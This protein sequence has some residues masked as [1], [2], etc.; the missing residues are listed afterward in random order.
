MKSRHRA[1]PALLVLTTLSVLTA[2]V[3]AQT[4]DEAPT[5]CCIEVYWVGSEVGQLRFIAAYTTPV[6]RQ[7][8]S[9]HM[10]RLGTTLQAANKSCCQFC[11]AWAEWRQIQDGIR[12]TAEE[13]LDSPQS[14]AVE[15][16]QVFREWVESRPAELIEGLS[17]CDLDDDMP[18]KWLALVDCARAYFKLGAQLGHATHA[19]SAASEGVE[20]GLVPNRSARQD[21]LQSL[22]AAA[23]LLASLR[24]GSEAPGSP[25]QKM[26]CDFLWNTE[27]GVERLLSEALRRPDLQT[28]A[29]LAAAA[30]EADGRV[31]DLLLHGRPDLGISPCPIGGEHDHAECE[32]A[33][34]AGP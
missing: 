2:N 25:G 3:A 6:Y 15:T 13:L 20:V 27:I 24:A 21:G 9:L 33:K 23:S 26:H 10:E 5:N 7:A 14:D 34:Q 17:R 22:E 1:V 4:V 12:A 28:D 8:A 31:Q 19:L 16:R 29:Q 18:C 11:E 32:A 30:A